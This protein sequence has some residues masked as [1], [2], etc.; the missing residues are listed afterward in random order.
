M[1]WTP[2]QSMA[3]TLRDK[4]ILVAAAAGSGKTAVLV[5]RIKRLVLEEMCPIDRM[6]IVTFTNAAAAEM[7]EK[8]RKALQGAVDELA[9][10]AVNDGGGSGDVAGDGD[11]GAD[12]D[13]EQKEYKEKLDFLRQ[14]LNN[15]PQAQISTFHS[16]ALEVIRKYFYIIDVEPN[17]KICDDAQ[18]AILKAEALDAL[19]DAR[20]EESDPEFLHFLD[21]YSGE[22]N[23]N[24]VRELID[25][26]YRTIDAL[27]EPYVWLREKTEMLE[28][29]Q[30]NGGESIRPMLDFL[31]EIAE[32]NL[33]D[34]EAL[35]QENIQIA[36]ENDMT[37]AAAL[38]ESDLSKIQAVREHM[39]DYDDFRTALGAIKFDRLK[40][41]ILK[42]FAVTEEE[43]LKAVR[44]EQ[45]WKDNRKDARDK[46]SELKKN[47]FDMDLE[48]MAQEMAQTS[49][50]MKMLESLV[51]EYG[52]RYRDEKKE[53]CLMDFSDIEHYAYEILKDEEVSRY[54]RE[55]FEHIFVDEYQDSNV[56]QEAFL[57]RVARENNLFLVGDVKQ[58]IYKFRLAEPE[59]FQ[60]RYKEYAS[61]D[62]KTSVKIDLNKNFRS[63]RPII[64]FVNDI[65]SYL[66]EDYDEAAALNM[67]DPNGDK[68]YHEP[69]LYLTDAEWNEDEI[70]S[71]DLKS[72]I[73]TEKEALAAVKIIKESLGKPFFD[74][75][76]G[77]E[78]PLEL[79]DI[80]IL[81]RGVRGQ[82]E[83]Y[84]NVLME[85]G[86]PAYVADD[87]GYFD[88]M[89]I[90]NF[91]SLLM[92]LDNEKQDVQLLTVLRSEIFG[93]TIAELAQIR[94]HSK[95]GS[96]YS[97][98]VEYSQSG[99]DEA[100]RKKSADALSSIA[101]WQSMA[102]F[103]PIEE[104]IWKLMLDTGFYI[105]VGAM[106]GGRQRQANLR[107]LVDKA[108]AYR[109]GE[110]GSLY[111]FIR[112]IEA[113][114]TRKVPS[115]Q[116]KLVGEGDEIVK[117]MTVHKSKGLEFPMVILAGYCRTLRYTPI[118]SSAV[119][120]KDFGVALPIVN[121]EKYLSL[122][123]T[124]QKII[125]EKLHME[126][127]AEEERILYVALTRPKDRLV[128]LGSHQNM[129][130]FFEKNKKNYQSY[131]HMTGGYIHNRLHRCVILDD[132]D[133]ARLITYR[134]RSNEPILRLFDQD[135]RTGND[136]LAEKV[137]KQIEFR[138]P[139]Q[140][141]MN[142]K[143]KY[144]VS[145]LNALS[146]S[147]EAAM[148]PGASA[149]PAGGS[150]DRWSLD[151]L[152]EPASFQKKEIFTAAQKGT[153]Y[154]TLLEH[155]QFQS[156]YA[157]ADEEAERAEVEATCQWLVDKQFLT[158][159][160]A[161]V[162]DAD[163]VLKLIHT[164]LGQRL[165]EAD[166]ENLLWK[167][168]PFNLKMAYDPD[169]SG[170]SS[171]VF[172]QGVIDCY[173]Q[174]ADGLVLVDYKTSRIRTNDGEH[175]LAAE[176]N[177]IAQ[178]YRTQIDI[179]RQ[180]LEEATGKTVK[181]AYIYLT[182]CGEVIEM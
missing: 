159:E 12:S 20:Y 48:S 74:S 102:M 10:S 62:Q 149:A 64:N 122:T 67:G 173:F 141:E 39:G 152:K 156:L 21:C 29:A 107:A 153:I 111:G 181:E 72:M 49:R 98:F 115:G 59:I 148:L 16:F 136:E 117:I 174:E 167:E 162:L 125:K 85:N 75:K 13:S 120:H 4:N 116:V 84:Y 118:G 158:A 54:Y 5:E 166:S 17:F 25:E 6:L 101:D 138:Y 103:M 28:N 79:K 47:L 77:V 99:D 3:I 37:E 160:E 178:Q 131:F 114:K 165:A 180:A 168:Q 2:E 38:A 87:D 171:D 68:Y 132:S 11:L 164:E 19:M 90:N 97:A 137:R 41:S 78:R 123:T 9:A 108:L 93:F 179:Y 113:L 50:E 126:E 92:L 96:Y 61:G 18:T 182:N 63:K 56:M 104:L 177:R 144:S 119:M 161:E 172:V 163:I 57:G 147:T 53:R 35:I 105:S 27:P 73:K 65:F 24:A 95:A 60:R 58:S 43:V 76:A 124:F 127:R 44:R 128:I 121:P 112:Y 89:E 157:C 51:V 32:E 23:D 55:K 110:R 86:I 94:I 88:T 46:V 109:K 33:S 169:G 31:F 139:H 82:G 154:H 106:P 81:M 66:M 34:A 70:I 140:R 155:I 91:L 83:I 15:L 45:K 100:L 14:Q 22:R 129:D 145:E 7:K 36:L 135:N 26:V 71:D 150:I 42:S 176:K 170:Q 134:K 142:I 40:T 52:N 130:K 133:L 1:N 146:E 30:Y 8:I 175:A 143:S 80:V 69:V 151:S